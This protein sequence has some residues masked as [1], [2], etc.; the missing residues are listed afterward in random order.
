MQRFSVRLVACSAVL[1]LSA[2]GTPAQF[3]APGSTVQGDALRGQ[4]VFLSGAGLYNYY[5][6]MGDSISTDTYIRL[7]EYIYN[8]IKHENA[9]RARHRAA[10]IARRRENYEE[11]L[12]RIL[13]NP[14]YRDLAR[15]DALNAL[16]DELL[17]PGAIAPSSLRLSPIPLAGETVRSIPFFYAPED[18]TI[19]MRRLSAHGRWPVG[20]RGEP[21][22]PERRAYERAVDEALEQQT[23]GEMSREAIRAV[24]AALNDLRSKLDRVVPPSN[25]RVYVEA[26]NHLKRLEVSKELLKRRVIEQIVGELDKYSGTTVRDLLEFMRRNNLRFG[27]SE[28]GDEMETYPKLYAALKQQ[29]DAVGFPGRKAKKED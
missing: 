27:V 2:R 28:I 11:I 8:S 17:D 5:T 25:D 26:K 23:E 4:G 10:V 3:I 19:S 6:A 21:L 1:C 22:A 29:L 15:G 14:D 18:A 24:E 7:N 9:E 13:S 20:L 12:D 16:L